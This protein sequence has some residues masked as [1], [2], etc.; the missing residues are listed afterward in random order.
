MKIYNTLTR[1]KEVL[2][3]LAAARGEKLRLFVCGPTVYDFSHIGHARTYIAFDAFVRYLRSTKYE[4]FYLQNITD[5]DDKI[6]QRAK[7]ANTNSRALAKKFEQE[8]L[9][10][11]K[12]LAVFSVT[13]YARATDYI[14]EI[15]NQIERLL[16]KRY[17]YEIPN[18][19]IYFDVARFRHYGELSKRKAV[20]AEDAVSRIDESVQKRNKGDFAL[21][22]FS[23]PEEPKWKSP[24]GEGR[25]GWHIEDTAITETFFGQQYDIHGGARDLIFPH[26]D[27][28]ISQMEAISGKHPLAKFWMHTGFLT[29]KGE[30]MA[31]SLG[32]FITIRDFLKKH[33]ARALRLLVLKTLYRSPIDYSEKS[34]EQVS[35]ELSRIDEFVSKLQAKK[36]S[37]KAS[38]VNVAR[39]EVQFEKALEDDFNTSKAVAVVFELAR[40]ANPFLEQNLLS[41]KD[42][43]EILAFLKAA[44]EVFGL[45]FW[46]KKNHR[47]VSEEVKKLVEAREKHRKNKAWK[48]ADEVRKRIEQKGWI[49]EDTASGPRLKRR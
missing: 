9:K 8:Y 34:M 43:R 4:V 28:E 27:A 6:I 3:P 5:V 22:K 40:K 1:K 45:I 12:S 7:E 31:K 48:E 21:W 41:Q 33:S 18:D 26:H 32:N 29:V 25:P 44:D 30:K 23:K 47:G 13:K 39:F 17:A 19:G 10:D 20:H 2:K 16:K 14:E 37:R 35:Q 24:W 36:F 49:V 11:M 38:K 46:G 15:I 42:V